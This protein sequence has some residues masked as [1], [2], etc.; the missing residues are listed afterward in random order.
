MNDSSAPLRILTVDIGGTGIKAAV[1]DRDGNLLTTRVRV[2][3]PVPCAPELLVNTIT[4]LV[5]PLR[6]PED[7]TCVSV[8]FPGVVRGGK[9]LTAPNLGTALLAGFDLAGELAGRFHR[10]VRLLNDADLQALA[11]VAGHGLELV[12][13]LGTGLG[14]ALFID[15]RLMPHL[16]LSMHPFHKGK[17]YNDVLGDAARKKLGR[18]KWNRRV[19]LAIDTL[20]TLT[21]FDHLYIGGGNSQRVTL[22]LPPDVSLVSNE[23]GLRGG[24]GLWQREDGLPVALGPAAASAAA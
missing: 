5:E 22:E 1:L 24:A 18:K 9:I 21:N 15:G 10:P 17:I 23:N 16:E 6:A 20:R 19:Q 8:G 14:S 13:T 3:T 4:E 7:F 12:I 2:P 11:T